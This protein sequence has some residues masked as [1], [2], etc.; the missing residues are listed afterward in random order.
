M[1]TFLRSL[2]TEL[3][4]CIFVNWHFEWVVQSIMQNNDIYA[5][6]QFTVCPTNIYFICCICKLTSPYSIRIDCLSHTQVNQIEFKSLSKIN[7]IGNRMQ[8][9]SS[10]NSRFNSKLKRFYLLFI[11]NL[12]GIL[13]RTLS[14][15]LSIESIIF[16]C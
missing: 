1:N 14:L 5:T 4:L 7:W 10:I 12:I 11:G 13:Y 15:S 8:C 3:E 2:K 6:A 9:C 16:N